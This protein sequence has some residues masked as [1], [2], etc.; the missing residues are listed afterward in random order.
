VGLA[1]PGGGPLCAEMQVSP[2]SLQATAGGAP[3][4]EV[5][6]CVSG[7]WAAKAIGDVELESASCRRMAG[8]SNKGCHWRS[9]PSRSICRTTPTCG[10]GP[11][12]TRSPGDPPA[13]RK[14]LCGCPSKLIRVLGCGSWKTL[15]LMNHCA[16]CKAIVPRPTLDRQGQL[17]RPQ[18]GGQCRPRGSAV[19][20]NPESPMPACAQGS[21]SRISAGT[22]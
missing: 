12:P 8:L 16:M 15:L 21:T 19:A 1:R 4:E 17:V 3:A 2:G 22:G 11:R 9:M 6:G 7:E 18:H 5:G 20:T 13:P 10:I 14:P